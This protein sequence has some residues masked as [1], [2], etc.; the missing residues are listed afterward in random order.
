[1]ALAENDYQGQL[2]EFN[3]KYGMEGYDLQQMA[4][5]NEKFR[6]V[7]NFL[8]ND[9]IDGP[10]DQFI[11]WFS[12]TIRIYF[13]KHSQFSGDWK[14]NLSKY[15]SQEF[16]ND[17]EKVAKAK[18]LSELKEGQEPDRKPYAGAKT[19]QIISAIAPYFQEINKP[20]PTVWME[21]MKKGTMNVTEIQQL[22][23][24]LTD[25]LTKNL[26]RKATMME[27]FTRIVAAREA[28]RQLRES[29][30]HGF[31]GA[32]WWLFNFRINGRE[33][34]CLEALN[35]CIK[36]WE[37]QQFNTEKV[38]GELMGKTALD[39]PVNAAEKASQPQPQAAEQIQNEPSVN[40][41]VNDAPIQ[42]VKAPQMDPVAKQLDETLKKV[43]AYAMGQ[44][45]HEKLPANDQ[46]EILRTLGFQTLWKTAT[47]NISQINAEFDSAIATGAD[48]KMEM[49][50]VVRK[51]F[52]DAFKAVKSWGDYSEMTDK[53]EAT[54]LVAQTILERHT[55]LALHPD[56]LGDAVKG[57]VE[58][59]TDTMKEL[60]NKNKDFVS[61][62]E[63]FEFKRMNAVS[64]N[65]VSNNNNEI[66]ANKIENEKIQNNNKG[67]EFNDD[68]SE[69][70]DIEFDDD[71]SSRSE[72][73]MNLNFGVNYTDN[74]ERVFDNANNPFK[75]DNN[76]EKSKPVDLDDSVL[77]EEIDLNV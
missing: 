24:N 64:S 69:A 52:V 10:S 70:G 61:E 2:K 58:Q 39:R 35:T 65:S 49:D 36:T 19:K 15:H 59:Y 71:D 5:I 14:K 50:H 27:S 34:D 62:M 46:M 12:K 25:G 26:D 38:L 37:A 41:E 73:E 23:V 47:N 51:L 17:F 42:E 68:D 53:I 48:P 13:E 29:R 44:E 77:G 60:S 54:K 74:K 67:L 22:C 30:P 72:E 40:N 3:D 6:V 28:V 66:K 55:A 33:R 11:A 4:G 76:L 9:T 20:L 56:K 16:L 18:Y 75:E 7:N 57:Y 32:I 1:M 63:E 43:D 8:M 21:R 45:L 31:L